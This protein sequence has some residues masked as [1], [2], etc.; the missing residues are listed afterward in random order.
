MA[1]AV[2]D[3]GGITGESAIRVSEGDI[4]EFSDVNCGIPDSGDSSG[5]SLHPESGK[6]S[7]AISSLS[8]NICPADSGDNTASSCFSSVYSSASTS[9]LLFVSLLSCPS[10]MSDSFSFS[11]IFH[12]RKFSGLMISSSHCVPQK[13]AFSPISRSP[14]SLS[15]PTP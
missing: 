13:P 14:P 2:P 15:I 3:S 6:F 5:H 12:S 11:G 9:F 4:M 1:C 8:E 10:E 7:S